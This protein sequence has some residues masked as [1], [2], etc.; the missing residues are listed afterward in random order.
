VAETQTPGSELA[1]RHE[2]REGA[3]S[4]F[5]EVG[6]ERLA[7]LRYSRT[8][9]KDVVLEHTDVS[10]K[11]KGRGVGRLLVEAAVAWARR[12]GTGVS[13][14]CPYARSV[15]DKSPELRDVLG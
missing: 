3:G 12:T 4:F 10:G 13:A 15:F 14:S 1:V 6:G 11:L 2:E 5:V 8:S 9:P 7:E